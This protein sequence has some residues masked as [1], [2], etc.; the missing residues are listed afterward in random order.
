MSGIR[1]LRRDDIPAVCALYERVVRSGTTEYPAALP[2]YFEQTLLDHPWFDDGIP[3]LVYETQD[4]EIVGFLGSYARR[5]R[6]DGRRLRLACSGQL[7]AAPETRH[8]GV[9]ALLLRRY[10]A[11]PQ[12]I[13]ITDGATNYVRRIW[14]GL[15]GRTD[16]TASIG[17]VKFLRPSKVGTFLTRRRGIRWLTRSIG[18]VGSGVDAALR[19]IAHRVPGLLPAEPATAVEE[20]GPADLVEQI[21]NAARHLRL[22]PDYDAAYVE[23]LFT[24]LSAVSFR[25]TP[26]RHLVRDGRGR[27]LGW[28]IYYLEPG[29]IAQVM[30]VAAPDGEMGPVLGHLFWHADTNGAAAV[31]GR[32]EAHTMSELRRNRCL[33]VPSEWSLVHSQDQSVLALLGTPETLL[34]RLDGEWWMGHHSLWLSADAIA[35]RLA[36]APVS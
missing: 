33:L 21:D 31:T 11:G 35:A 4:G 23:W 30:Q 14:T 16:T 18:L 32:V 28:Y 25:G 15:G 12:D 8:A 22:R 2:A 36:A 9:G 10:L 29:S 7:V 27:V 20:L 34:T 6:L 5:M 19:R 3:S 26:V 1:A 17:W 13:T 24:E